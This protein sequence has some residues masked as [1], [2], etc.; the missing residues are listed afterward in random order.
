[1]SNIV[2]K[3]ESFAEKTLQSNGGSANLV[4]QATQREGA[5]TPAA[6][7]LSR[8]LGAIDVPHKKIEKICCIGAGYVGKINSRASSIDFSRQ[9]QFS[10]PSFSLA[11]Y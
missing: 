7:R 2:E 3:M 10:E 4:V 6:K 8:P 9:I 11:T 1:M 5:V